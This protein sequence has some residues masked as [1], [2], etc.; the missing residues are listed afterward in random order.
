GVLSDPHSDGH[1]DFACDAPILVEMDTL[2][3]GEAETVRFR[4][5]FPL[6]GT[7]HDGAIRLSGGFVF[8]LEGEH[9]PMAAKA[10]VCQAHISASSHFRCV[11]VDDSDLP[12][13]A[14]TN[15]IALGFAGREAAVRASGDFDIA[16]RGL[17]VYIT[18]LALRATP[19]AFP[20]LFET[21][22]IGVELLPPAPHVAFALDRARGFAVRAEIPAQLTTHVSFL[23]FPAQPLTAALRM[24]LRGDV[25]LRSTV[26]LRL[27]DRL[28][29]H[30]GDGAVTLSVQAMLRAR[31]EAVGGEADL[32]GVAEAY[33]RQTGRPS[34][35]LDGAAVAALMAALAH[36]ADLW[37][38]LD[39][40]L[41]LTDAPGDVWLAACQL[42]VTD[43]DPVVRCHAA[44]GLG[45]RGDGSPLRQDAAAALMTMLHDAN[46][47]ARLCAGAAVLRLDRDGPARREAVR[48]VIGVLRDDDDVCVQMVGCIHLAGAPEADAQRAIRAAEVRA[49]D[50][51]VRRA[52]RY[53]LGKRNR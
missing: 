23:G 19:L 29:V 5:H 48:A 7:I 34:R 20:G 51:F 27:N 14:E 18:R 47:F 12:A 25:A 36:D 6:E 11:L 46:P 3:Q 16:L 10:G 4:T 38:R 45:R 39:A 28:D 1:F 33:P 42:G 35:Q 43:G 49:R 41:A 44:E 9:E 21:G 8:R 50:S 30:I 31:V 37:A 22:P 13:L 17:D 2:T 40:L 52:V 32:P 53:A 26:T 24:E 15:T